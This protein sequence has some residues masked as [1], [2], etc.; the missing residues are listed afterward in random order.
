[1]V[2][3]SGPLTTA[4]RA[5]DSTGDLVKTA[6]RFSLA[7]GLF[8][9]EQTAVLFGR[10]SGAGAINRV[11]DAA[12]RGLTG[13]LRT[14][15]AIGPISNT[16]SST[17]RSA[18]QGRALAERPRPGG[19]RSCASRSPRPSHGACRACERWRLG[20]STGPSRRMSSSSCSPNT[21]PTRRSVGRRFPSARQGSGS[22]RVSQP[23]LASSFSRATPSPIRRSPDA[24][25]P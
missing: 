17:R 11:T 4:R 5:V 6:S 8:A 14:A 24:C 22:P 13:G 3:R 12:G 15:L 10:R 2:N 7:M 23:P 19:R 9:A 20:R 25:C 16:D 21:T 1:M 18:S